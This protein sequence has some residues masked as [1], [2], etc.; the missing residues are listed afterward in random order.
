MMIFMVTTR[1]FLADEPGLGYHF[2]PMVG[3][4]AE[5]FV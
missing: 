4:S 1:M 5:P 3:A 2:V